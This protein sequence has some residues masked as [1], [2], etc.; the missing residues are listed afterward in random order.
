MIAS[1]SSI[2]ISGLAIVGGRG[3]AKTT[4]AKHLIRRFMKEK[5]N[6]RIRAFEDAYEFS[7]NSDLPFYQILTENTRQIF[8]KKNYNLA[9][10]NKGQIEMRA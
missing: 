4:T 10:N 8:I 6:V 9:K 3:T 1:S 7:K 2:I 5:A